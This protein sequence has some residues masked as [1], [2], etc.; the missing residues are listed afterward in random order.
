MLLLSAA[1]ALVFAVG[2]ALGHIVASMFC[3]HSRGISYEPVPAPEPII[4]PYPPVDRVVPVDV[5]EV[6]QKAGLRLVEGRWTA[7][8]APYDYHKAFNA[9]WRGRVAS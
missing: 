6:Y 1:F 8:E 4:K 7:P 3:S 2:C 5:A 9:A